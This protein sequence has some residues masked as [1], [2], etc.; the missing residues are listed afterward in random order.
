MIINQEAVLSGVAGWLLAAVAPNYIR[1]L[2]HPVVRFDKKAT[3]ASTDGKIINMPE[4]FEGD[5]VEG[6]LAIG[7]ISHEI[8]HWMQNLTAVSEW[9]S[10]PERARTAHDTV[11][12]LLDIALE[13]YIGAAAPALKTGFIAL[14]ER[15]RAHSAVNPTG[16]IS[17][18]DTLMKELFQTRFRAWPAGTSKDARI[19]N[20]V[21]LAKSWATLDLMKETVVQNALEEAR[22]ICPILFDKQDG[23]ASEPE[24]VIVIALPAS[25]GNL[26]ADVKSAMSE[27]P[28]F[29]E[30]TQF[31][32][33]ATELVILPTAPMFAETANLAKGL[34]PQFYRPNVRA[35]AVG[36]GGRIDRRALARGEMFHMISLN[37]K[38][39]AGKAQDV[40]IF[41]DHSGSMSGD[42]WELAARAAEAVWYAI[43]QADPS[44]RASLFLFHDRLYRNADTQSNGV[45]HTNVIG[46][47]G[48]SFDWLTEVWREFPRETI[49]VVTDGGATAPRV[50]SQHDKARTCVI[51]IGSAWGSSATKFSNRVQN[52]T[53]LREL[54]QAMSALIPRGYY[55][56]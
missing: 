46:W 43:K 8:G 36:A 45:L 17:E 42:Q 7:L 14:G 50:M 52:I 13:T 6:D 29:G 53:N 16:P 44:N 39:G 49:I 31:D 25:M 34:A 9:T 48:T 3:T 51:E 24:S 37:V 30:L 2:G 26:P 18:R 54:P 28:P 32:P 1:R 33:G 55:L 56:A 35:E 23:E 4:T 11:N 5:K 41:V 10:Q 47:G 38:K 21:I 40:A 22:A 27:K 15:V 20:L 19:S 12:I